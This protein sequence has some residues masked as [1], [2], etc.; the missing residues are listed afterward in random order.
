MKTRIF[1]AMVL[2]VAVYG[3]TSMAFAANPQIEQHDADMTADHLVLESKI[4]SLSSSSTPSVLQPVQGEYSADFLSG[5]FV[6]EAGRFIVPSNRRLVIELISLQVSGNDAGRAWQVFATTSIGG[7]P[8]EHPI[9][10]IIYTGDGARRA[11]ELP[12]APF[13]FIVESFHR[14][15]YADPNTDVIFTVR[16]SGNSLTVPKTA[17]VTFSGRLIDVP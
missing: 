11:T 12:G 4:D 7:S 14:T 3:F 5:T 6:V 16:G 2:L 8:V 17:K 10:T 15:L 1:V 13:A 9:G